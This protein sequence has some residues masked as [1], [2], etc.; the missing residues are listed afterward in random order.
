MLRHYYLPPRPSSSVRLII[1]ATKIS[2]KAPQPLTPAWGIFIKLNSLIINWR[3]IF[4]HYMGITTLELMLGEF[5]P[6]GQLV[7]GVQALEV[8]SRDSPLKTCCL[9]AR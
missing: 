5:C 6:L 2:S 3:S 9:T 8:S 4:F 7:R 1:R